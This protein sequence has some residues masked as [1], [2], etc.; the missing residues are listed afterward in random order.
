MFYDEVKTS[1]LGSRAH[2]IKHLNGRMIFDPFEKM[3]EGTLW[4][5]P[6][7]LIY[8]ILTKQIFLH[9]YLHGDCFYNQYAKNAKNPIT[10]GDI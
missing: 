5:G 10:L 1:E 8:F 4:R 2:V 9:I 6:R 3:H 7:V